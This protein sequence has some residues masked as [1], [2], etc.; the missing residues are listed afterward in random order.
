MAIRALFLAAIVG[1]WSVLTPGGVPHGAAD[2][3]LSAVDPVPAADLVEATVP[4]EMAP[5]SEVSLQRRPDQ[6]HA[7]SQHRPDQ[8][9]AASEHHPDQIH[10][11]SEHHL[12]EIQGHADLIGQAASAADVS[13]G[14]ESVQEDSAVAPAPAEA[15]SAGAGQDPG[16]PAPDAAVEEEAIEQTWPNPMASVLPGATVDPVPAFSTPAES[17]DVGR[18][19]FAE[20]PLP[21]ATGA[22]PAPTAPYHLVANSQVGFFLDRFTREGRE[23]ISTY[24]GRSGRFMSMIR[25][26]LKKHG[27]PE[28]LVFTAMIESGFNPM[29]TSRAGARGL[30][31]FMSAT[32]KRYGLRVDQW[33]DERLDPEK[34]TVAAAAYLRDLYNLFGSWFLAQAAYNAGEATIARA[35]RAT[36]SSDFWTLA[37]TGFLHRETRE[38]VPQIVAAT[39]I[40]R[41]PHR[42]G[43][44]PVQHSAP[45]VDRVAVPPETDLRWLS[46]STGIAVDTLKSLNLALVKGVTPPDGHFELNVPE[47]A[48]T[49]VL[50]AVQRPRRVVVTFPG[51]GMARASGDGQA[52]HVVR[53]RDTVQSIARRYGVSVGDVLRWNDLRRKDSIRPGDRLRITTIPGG[54]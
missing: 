33:V 29:A 27:L 7:A 18:P 38:F 3:G 5:V 1:F 13:P 35:I 30:W 20:R 52:I 28:D 32:A 42:F 16:A 10:V 8:I 24:L 49:R 36:G 48:S 51:S 2:P 25:E 21:V 17:G 54:R 22:R 19:S 12:G 50:A 37:R 4:A 31:Q 44:E 15:I 34:S 14:E 41:E 6:I 11:A 40:G 9:H 45:A 46:A 53:P 23:T 39:H 43:F 26:T 47:G